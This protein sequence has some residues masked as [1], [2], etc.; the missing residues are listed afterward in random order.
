MVLED[1]TLDNPI[2]V[3]GAAPGA[4]RIAA[5]TA[6]ALG[7]DVEAYRADWELHGNAAGPIR[8]QAMVD[9][10]ADLL[11]AFGGG[12]GTADCIHRARKAGIPVVEVE[13]S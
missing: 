4:D 13:R 12:L 7:L 8:N 5:D 3:H 1:Q 10:G 9:A 2:I 6:V 11:I